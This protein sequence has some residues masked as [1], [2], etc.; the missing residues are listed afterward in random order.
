MS[1]DKAKEVQPQQRDVV[2]TKG[3]KSYVVEGNQKTRDDSTGGST[4]GTQSYPV[5]GK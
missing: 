3:E 5:E 4:K 1:D 2:P